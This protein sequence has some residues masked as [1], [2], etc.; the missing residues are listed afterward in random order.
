MDVLVKEDKLIKLAY[1][2]TSVVKKHYGKIF[3]IFL[4]LASHHNAM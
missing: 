4:I 3:I 2:V 1:N